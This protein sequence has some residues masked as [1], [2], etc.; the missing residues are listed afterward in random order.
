MG[1]GRD[2]A[3]RCRASHLAVFCHRPL[4]PALDSY[5]VF[6]PLPL[7]SPSSVINNLI[8]IAACYERHDFSLHC[9]QEQFLAPPSHLSAHSD[10]TPDTTQ[11]A[12]GHLRYTPSSP[13]VTANPLH[14]DSSLCTVIRR[15]ILPLEHYTD[16]QGAPR[17]QAAFSWRW[18]STPV[19]TRTEADWNCM[20]GVWSC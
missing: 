7:P 14:V 18:V 1:A 8:S 13:P 2:L 19:V 9:I 4:S 15:P 6:P 12:L 17:R 3:S 5:R 10:S 20:A 11:F 16:P